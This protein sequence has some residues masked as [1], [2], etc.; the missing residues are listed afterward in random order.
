MKHQTLAF[1]ILS[2]VFGF[3]QIE[4]KTDSAPQSYN[5]TRAME[6]L[7]NENTELATEYLTKE[8][9]LVN[10]SSGL[11]RLTTRVKS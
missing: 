4:A 6:E 11:S 5:M 3:F 8:L 1:I 10:Q 9:S 7:R 2:V